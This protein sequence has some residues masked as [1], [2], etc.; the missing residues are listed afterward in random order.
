MPLRP[1]VPALLYLSRYVLLPNVVDRS[2][3]G[4][5]VLLLVVLEIV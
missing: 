2:R 3:W 1:Y 5:F 4:I